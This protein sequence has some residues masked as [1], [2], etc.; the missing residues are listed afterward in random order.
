[1]EKDRIVIESEELLQELGF[2]I[3]WSGPYL[4]RIL[5]L[6]EGCGDAPI[7][8]GS[9][10]L[11]EYK[12]RHFILTNE[13]VIRLVNNPEKDIIVPYSLSN[14][15]TYKMTIKSVEKDSMR[16]IAILEVKKNEPFDKSNHQFLTSANI[17][18]DTK[19]YIEKTNIIFMHGYP[20]FLTSVDYDKRVIDAETFPYCT[21]VN[22]FDEKENS[23]MINIGEKGISEYKEE[24]EIPDVSG[25]SGS[26]VYAFYIEGEPRY[27][28]LGILTNWYRTENLLEVYPINEFIEFIEE[29]FF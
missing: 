19:S 10:G 17:E 1:M 7:P 18:F 2:F 20:T 23:L 24:V 13:H 25:M 14:E 12:E 3:P 22:E 29:N 11:L 5:G 6:V 8:L 26:F 9:G 21:F 27:K 4:V 16:D 15:K 28:C